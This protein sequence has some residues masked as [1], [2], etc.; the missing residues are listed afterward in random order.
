MFDLTVQQTIEGS[1]KSFAFQNPHVFCRRPDKQTGKS[2]TYVIQMSRVQ[3]MISHGITAASFKPGDS[4]MIKINPMHG[5]RPGAQYIT[6][7][8]DGKEY[9]R[10]AGE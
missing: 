5:G 7:S 8:K 3:N 9:G 6:V 2:T 10:G 4:M 1:V